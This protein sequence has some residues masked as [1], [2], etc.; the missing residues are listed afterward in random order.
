M[1]AKSYKAKMISSFKL[2]DGT[3][4]QVRRLKPQDYVSAGAIP[5][6]LYDFQMKEDEKRKVLSDK[7][8]LQA[9]YKVAF[10]KGVIPQP[11][12]VPVDKPEADLAENEICVDLLTE[13]EK[14]IIMAKTVNGGI[15]EEPIPFPEDGAKQ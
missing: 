3:I 1:G 9:L 7:S 11:D 6:V 2:G 8:T 12:F 10:L 14:A 15:G 4:V 13:W 5:D